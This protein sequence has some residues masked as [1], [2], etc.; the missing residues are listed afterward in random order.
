[1]GRISI[2]YC[3]M[4]GAALLGG[5]NGSI[6][7]A[8]KPVQANKASDKAP[9][10]TDDPASLEP[11]LQ[12]AALQSSSKHEYAEAAAYWGAIYQASPEDINAALQYASNLRYSGN[13][14]DAVNVL[15]SA[16]QTHPGDGRLLAA[17]G[18]AYTALGAIEPALED[19][20]KAI[21]ASPADWTLYSAQGV[22]LDRMGRQSEAEEAYKK[23]L[24]ISPD[25]PKILNN[26]ALGTALGGRHEE[27]VEIMRRAAE[28]PDAT[29]QIRQNLSLLLA[30]RGD[31]KQAAQLARA[32][33]PN[34]VAENNLSYYEGLSPASPDAV[35]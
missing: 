5:C 20:T 26:L 1:M 4:L 8:N 32:D 11:Y 13:P 14:S 24:G 6:E 16:I 7:R 19:I 35:E 18:K 33:L 15:S 31:T 25:N 17:R 34:N 12:E 10:L 30:M 27:A 21:A 28:H 2:V 22:A 23:A 3:L 9:K 29:M